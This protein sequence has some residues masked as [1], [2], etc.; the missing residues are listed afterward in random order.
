MTQ[1]VDGVRFVFL[2]ADEDLLRRRLTGRRGHF[3]GAALVPSQLATLEP[4]A[5]AVTID[6]RRSP[7]EIV[8]EIV[9][10]LSAHNPGYEFS[11][12]RRREDTVAQLP[13]PDEETDTET[14]LRELG[15]IIAALLDTNDLTR[16]QELWAEAKPRIE[17][18]DRLI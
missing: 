7:D 18:I 6:A 4:P 9:A 5:D 2:R 8:E 12:R 15:D 16:R 1:G 17:M 13:T 11:D 10:T 3:A 14:L